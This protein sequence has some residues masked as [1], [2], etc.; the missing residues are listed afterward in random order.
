MFRIDQRRFLYRASAVGL[1]GTF[2]KP[3][4]E[5]VSAQA[6]CALGIEGGIASAAVK[7]FSYRNIMSF[8]LAESHIL[9]Q[10]GETEGCYTTLNTVT[11]EGF[12][13]MNMLS[14]DGIVARLS[15]RSYMDKT[16]AAFVAVG[17]HFDNLRVAGQPVEVDL[18]EDV[19]CKWE[20]YEEARVGFERRD[21]VKI[22]DG[23]T[24]CG[25]I[26]SSISQPKGTTVTG[27]RIDIPHFGSIYL[28][29]IYISP[30][31]RR[32]QMI[33]IAFGCPVDGDGGVGTPENNGE[34]YPPLGLAG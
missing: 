15:S 29:E 2:N 24:Y 26:V 23:Q 3:Y 28:G 22:V 8:D 4:K 33:R 20:T 1:S 16:P 6:S 34:S 30:A 12:N 11:L 31:M 5:Y 18:D 25:S 9:G 14:C 7:D 21:H 32:M 19:L 10:P 13:V 27:N 17:S